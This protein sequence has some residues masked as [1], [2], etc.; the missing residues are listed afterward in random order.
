MEAI[1]RI[2]CPITCLPLTILAPVTA[3]Q[4]LPGS[5]PFRPWGILDRRRYLRVEAR[6]RRQR[7]D[8]RRG[9]EGWLKRTWRHVS[10]GATAT[11][12]TQARIRERATPALRA[13]EA[14]AAGPAP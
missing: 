9:S 4:I 10:H 12:V 7:Q 14:R 2:Y 6:S 13:V 5:G 8:R 11:S 1:G 3:R